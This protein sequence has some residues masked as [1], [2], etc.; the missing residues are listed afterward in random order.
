MADIDAVRDEADKLTS[1]I[2]ATSPSGE[3]WVKQYGKDP[4]THAKIIKIET[5]MQRSLRDYFKGLSDRAVRYVNWYAYAS[6]VQAADDFSV[7]VLINDGAL[8][9][10]DGL[11]MK[12][13][14]DPVLQGIYTGALAG[15]VIY[16][17]PVGTTP[18]SDFVQQ[19]ARSRVAELVGKKLDK[20]TGLIV[21]NP[22]SEYRITDTTRNEIRQ[23]I[24]TSLGLGETYQQAIS[25]M[26]D[27]IEND[28]RAEMIAATESV[29]AYQKGLVEFGNQSG[30]TAKEWISSNPNDECGDNDDAGIIDYNDTFPSGDDEPPAHPNCR[31]S[32]RLVYP[33]ELNSDAPPVDEFDNPL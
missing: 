4:Q 16:N 24:A 20:K 14:Y 19:A 30:A 2:L 31:C 10:E 28:A 21:D 15:E 12:V 26:Q 33:D 8:D 22:K 11:I 27:I 29:N 13:M 6:R 3:D 7:D 32:L 17:R 25:R 5:S 1:L 18:T 9:D 23:S